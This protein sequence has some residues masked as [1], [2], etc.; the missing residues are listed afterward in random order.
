MRPD[1]KTAV[2]ASLEALGDEFR[3]NRLAY[4]SLTAKNESLLCGALSR[5]LH[6][7]YAA[8]RNIQVRREWAN[9][10]RRFDLAVLRDNKPVALIE[11]K[12]ALS[13]N[14]PRSGLPHTDRVRKDIE[15]LRSV[16]FEGER[17]VLAFFTHP[18]QV[19]RAEYRDAIKY[20]GLIERQ[21]AVG[22]AEIDAGFAR[23]R[24]AVGSPPVLARGEVPAGRAFDV[25]VSVLYWLLDASD[26]S[27]V[28]FGAT[29]SA[30]Q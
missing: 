4:L 6:E 22:S 7:T 20:F 15:R 8:Q 14:L 1:V 28:S 30:S 5:R 12:T 24:E 19:P 9:E 21:G 23:F 29:G 25:D 10:R 11:A 16:E 26:G 3:P 13:A 17:W 27:P 18:R 2:T